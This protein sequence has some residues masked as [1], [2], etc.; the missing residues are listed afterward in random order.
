[1]LEVRPHHVGAWIDL[2]VRQAQAG[3]VDAGRRAFERALALDPDNPTTL[4]NL[5]NLELRAGRAEEGLAALDRLAAAGRF[6]AERGLRLGIELLLL[7]LAA[8]G[9][10]VLA[11]TDPRFRELTGE[12]AMALAE[13]FGRRGQGRNADGFRSHAHRLWAHEHAERGDFESARRSLFQNLR[14]T[15]DFAPGGPARVRAE[16]AAAL[17]LSD[18]AAEAAEWLTE[19]ELGARDWAALPEW[20]RD[21]LAEQAL[22]PR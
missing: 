16:Y 18:N 6:D 11:R 14:I 20:A 9:E 22:G 4:R 17:L 15:R 2:G 7:G 3:E 19:L 8:E 1:V 12:R 13:E 21:A 10:A 5:A